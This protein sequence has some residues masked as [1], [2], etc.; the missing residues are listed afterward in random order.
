MRIDLIRG[1]GYTGLGEVNA[2]GFELFLSPEAAPDAYRQRN[3]KQRCESASR[4]KP[5]I[6]RRGLVKDEEGVVNNKYGGNGPAQHF[7]DDDDGVAS[8]VERGALHRPA[9]D[10][11]PVQPQDLAEQPV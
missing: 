4:E 6:E 10:C 1:R 2:L 11:F 7:R 3:G 8:Y 9:L 5:G